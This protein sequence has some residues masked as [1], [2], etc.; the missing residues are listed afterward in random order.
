MQRRWKTFAK[1]AQN[2]VI[3]DFGGRQIRIHKNRK[4]TAAIL[5]EE[6][7]NSRT[8]AGTKTFEIHYSEK[9]S[10]R[11]ESLYAGESGE[12]SQNSRG[13]ACVEITEHEDVKEITLPLKPKAITGA[14]EK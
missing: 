13:Y 10:I 9:P 1:F 6:S 3:L 14:T 4:V 11:Q 2:R 12:H 7:Q 8:A 5:E